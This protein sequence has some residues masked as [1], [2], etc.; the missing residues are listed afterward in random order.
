MRHRLG[1]A[2]AK[3][4]IFDDAALAEVHRISQGVPRVINTLCDNALLESFLV[5]KDVV[6]AALVADVARDLGIQGL[7]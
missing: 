7:G 5:K 3:Q 4:G 2:G 6:S 1:V